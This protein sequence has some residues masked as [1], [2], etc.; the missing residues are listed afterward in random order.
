M[1]DVLENST[2][3]YV[4]AASAAALVV[5][6]WAVQS[7]A[8][9]KRSG[10]RPPPGPPGLPIVG[11]LS[12]IPPVDS[13]LAYVPLSKK[14]GPIMQFHGLGNTIIVINDLKMGIDLLEKR[15]AIYSGRPKL[16]MALESGFTWHVGFMPHNEA[17]RI[18]RTMV[19][20]KFHA[21]PTIE[22]HG[23]LRRVTLELAR[24]LLRTP[25]NFRE[26]IR[27]S[28][29]AS[30][31][32]AVYGIH[33][34]DTD[35]PYVEIA[36]KA[37]EAAGV[38]SIPGRNLINVIPSLRH[39]PPWVPFFG[40]WTAEAHKLRKY[41]TAMV[42]VPYARAKDDLSK[43]TAQP[44]MV[45]ENLDL[46]QSDP[47]ITEQAIKDACAISYLGGADTTVGTLVAFVMAMVLYPEYQRKAQAE[48]DRVLGDRLPD[49]ADEESLPYVEAI[50][51]ETYRRYPVTPLG[52]PH[53]VD[54]DDVYEGYFIKKGSTVMT[55]V[56]DIMHNSTMYPDPEKFNP[57]RF[58]KD[59]RIDESV[60]DPRIIAFGLGRRI[61]PGRHFADA[62]VFLTVATV[63]KCFDFGRHV[64]NGVEIPPSGEINTGIVSCP[65]PFKCNITPR[66]KMVGVL[67]DTSL[68]ANVE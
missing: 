55:N 39:I 53:A 24:G 6:R 49:F 33:V 58:L 20:Q 27:R 5:V 28:A 30:I 14:Y 41:P 4:A 13:H 19:H 11:N 35:D 3:L 64:E 59:G 31:M 37:M 67:I 38:V 56:W 60:Q 12:V 52:V 50:V 7:Y 17:W 45:H 42:E 62:S 18:R 1:L 44:C 25:E 34:A 54:E 61:C 65:V 43:G 8:R 22:M 57:D 21:K 9:Q 68:A 2:K 23:L 66:S 29:A 10:A 48:L 15:G 36:E 51:R 46:I 47:D 40:R 26:H 63:L 16:Y 32:K